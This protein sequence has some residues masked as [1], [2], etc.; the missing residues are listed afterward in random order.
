[1]ASRVN[2][3]FVVGLSVGLVL[4]F[5]AVA[6]TAYT[7]VYK[8]AGDLAKAG[9]KALAEGRIGDAVTQ[10][11]K[12]V[13]K[14]Q[15]NPEYL[16]KWIEAMGKDTPDT[17][18]KYVDRYRFWTQARRQLAVV[19][20]SNVAAQ[21]DHLDSLY[22][23][24]LLSP[25]RLENWNSA[26]D[27]A[28]LIIG[29]HEASPADGWEQ[30]RRYRGFINTRMFLESTRPEQK[31]VESAVADLEAALKADPTDDETAATLIDVALRRAQKARETDKL[32]E[33]AKFEAQADAVMSGFLAKSPDAPRMLLIQIQRDLINIRARV[34]AQGASANVEQE[35]KGFVER[36]MPIFTRA[37]E[38]AKQGP[39]PLS[40]MMLSQFRTVEGIVSPGTRGRQTEELVRLGLK[41]KPDDAKL[42]LS[43]AN[44]LSERAE[45]AAAVEQ[46]EAIEK[47]PSKPVSME[48]VQLFDLKKASLG[49]QA[50]W[51][52]RAWQ[53]IPAGPD[54]D[55]AMAKAKA[56]RERLA[57][58]VAADDRM[59]TLVDAQLA[60]VANTPEGN[61]NAARLLATYNKATEQRPD[62]DALFL[63]AQVAVRNN[64][65]GQARTSL[66]RVM[67]L[68]PTNITAILFLAETEARLQNMARSTQL[69]NRVLEL[70]PSN[71][72]A[73]Q[74]V[75]VTSN[76]ENP[77]KSTDPIMRVLVR[78]DE[79]AKAAPDA[80]NQEAIVNLLKSEIAK[81]DDVRLHRALVAVYIRMNDRATAKVAAETALAKFP[82]NRDLKQIVAQLSAK[83]DVAF[84]LAQIDAVETMDA[85][86]KD[87][88]K[89][90]V[91]RAA[92]RM[93]DAKAA[94]DRAK[95]A[96]PDDKR[97]V[98][99]TFQEAL[100]SSQFDVARPLVDKAVR[101]NFDNL[102]GDTFRARLLAAEGKAREAAALLQPH[103][104][105][106]GVQPEVYRLQARILMLD[107]RP[108]DAASALR[109]ALRI[110][111]NDP[112]AAADLLRAL[113]AANLPA[114]ALQAA[115]ENEKFANADPEFFN[116]WMGLEAQ[117]GDRA[118][119]KIRRERVATALPEQR[120]N[121]MALA[122]MCID[123]GELA[124]AQG[125]IDTL[126]KSGDNLDLV[127]MDATLRSRS[128]Q[129][130]DAAKVFD[131]FAAAQTEK[132]ILPML[133][134][135][136]FFA[137]RNDIA[138]AVATLEAA[139]PSQDKKIMEV[140]RTLS[141]LY[142]NAGMQKEAIAPSRAVVEAGADTPE[143]LFQKRVVELLTQTGSL[144]E[145]DAEYTKL[146][147]GREPDAVSLLLLAQLRGAQGNT[148]AQE[149]TLNLAV[150]RF[151]TVPT[152]FMR[153]AQ[154][155][156]Q[157]KEGVRDA[158]EDMNKAI[159]LAPDN[160]AFYRLR[161]DAHRANGDEKKVVEDLR[162]CLRINPNDTQLMFGLMDTLWRDGKEQIAQEVA[163]DV[164]QRRDR[165]WQFCVLL[166]NFY[167]SRTPPRFDLARAMNA[168]AYELNKTDFV[169]QNYL[170]SLLGGDSPNVETANRVLSEV[171]DRARNNPGFQMAGAKTRI[172]QG[173]TAEGRRAAVDVLKMLDVNRPEMMSSWYRDMNGVE[174]N[175]ADLQAF[176]QA[177]AQQGIAPD[178]MTFFRSMSMIEDATKRTEGTKAL[179]QAIPSFRT[180]ALQLLAYKTLGNAYY[181]LLD[182][183]AAARVW[184]AGSAAFDKDPELAN[185]AA[186]ILTKHLNKPAEGLV[187]AQRAV[188]ISPDVPDFLDTL[189]ATLIAN[190]KA[191]EAVPHLQ[192]AF[193][194]STNSGTRFTA[195]VHLVR[196]LKESSQVPAA[197]KLADDLNATVE[198]NPNVFSPELVGELQE[199]RDAMK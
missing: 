66:E 27:D 69:Y 111:P 165:D 71:E 106:G 121:Q 143:R 4:V 24:L 97:V 86:E 81:T 126:R 31:Q 164:L 124:K 83:D 199:L 145:A 50:L 147:A 185:N 19:E 62:P 122:Q 174:K 51:Q 197:K 153:R 90:N 46:L 78:V 148:Q 101:G 119:A 44:M 41:A 9:D 108:G 98:E 35:T 55:A 120:D 80:K 22:R 28:N 102:N 14:E 139:R 110:R 144:T 99:V 168:Q 116:L 15:A 176:L 38:K 186:F 162:T 89:F 136:Q 75:K 146:T 107:N 77:S 190:G 43:L 6:G 113:I 30:L 68:Q 1:M 156:M 63:S 179:E 91:N 161:A 61:R 42:L 26:L 112:Q 198:A 142:I 48:G 188:Q 103:V 76:L 128:Q 64:E 84:Q 192:R 171:G 191:A 167:S 7:L 25:Y 130:A 105:R 100:A 129:L 11:S 49:L 67:Q 104:A 57:G 166:A 53:T 32:D 70:D 193:D 154:L 114:Q 150:E 10:Y 180:P 8:S 189:G 96:A 54:K 56:L 73:T 141:D 2:T 33:A 175:K 40:E 152:V 183:P 177:T 158:I 155:L 181:Q 5:A 138:S 182:Y 65:L 94:L 37:H 131:E 172:L 125:I 170:D 18:V 140:D 23:G 115:R 163:A 151:P 16:K 187:L 178:W 196:A 135:A 133:A 29:F 132:S 95:A 134:K 173:R 109:E 36:N 127:I 47:L 195:G 160:T 13:N 39:H 149:S 85:I 34:Q 52:V 88:Q 82:D 79:M 17:E 87:L 3:K 184:S 137:G 74:A 92:G 117:Y 58:T 60:F 118:E 45:Y 169:V 20:Q 123:D 194:I 59:L 157:R 12:A 72:I 93:D 159:A 21:R